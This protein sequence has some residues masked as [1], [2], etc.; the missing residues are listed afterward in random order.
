MED[1]VDLETDLRKA[2]IGHPDFFEIHLV[3]GVNQNIAHSC[4]GPPRQIGVKTTE[5]RAETLGGLAKDLKTTDHG[6]LEVILG[7]EGLNIT[8]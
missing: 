4:H 1:A 6:I 7:E 3:V 5:F 8:G 2:L